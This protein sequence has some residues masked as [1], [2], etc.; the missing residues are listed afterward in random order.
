MRVLV[1]YAS[2]YGSTEG[3]AE[4]IARVLNEAGH[5]AT[6]A[7][8]SH[9]RSLEGYDAFVIGSALYMFSWLKEARDFV[10][11]NAGILATKPV[12]LFSSGPVGTQKVDPQGRDVRD[13]AGPR[14]LA[15][16]EARTHARDHRVFFGAFDHTK[17]TLG[18]RLLY[19]LPALKK[20]LPDG[21]FRDW[22]DIDSWAKTMALSLG[23]A[24]VPA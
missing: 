3:I 13:N 15:S 24:E 12:W 14:D 19:A 17:L 5:E 7:R 6:P 22:P 8:V 21:D 16:L 11:L 1:A 18:H 20:L 4:R 9:A 2:K 10:E 23:T